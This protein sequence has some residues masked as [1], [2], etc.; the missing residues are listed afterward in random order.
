MNSLLLNHCI[1][2]AWQTQTLALPNPSVAAI[3]TNS[4]GEILGIGTHCLAGSPHAEVIALKNAYIKL[5]N[6]TSLQSIESSDEIHK[7]LIAKHKDI[8][9]QCYLFVTLEP[10]NHYGKT[11]PCAN[12]IKELDLAKIFIA[13]K[14]SSAIAQGGADILRQSNIIVE[15]A[16]SSIAKN[17]KDLLYPFEMLRD[18]NS[19]VL[20]KLATRL[21]G[22]YNANTTSGAR[23]SGAD[24]QKF[25]HNQR[26]ICNHIIISG[27]T[28]KT[29]NP[30][31]DSRFADIKYKPKSIQEDSN[32]AR[33]LPK[34]SI[35]SRSLKELPKESNLAK[36]T[37]RDIKICNDISQLDL[38]GF[39]IIE[40]GLTMLDSV[41]PFIDMLL[42]HISTSLCPNP[43]HLTH[44]VLHNFKLLKSVNFTQDLALWLK[45]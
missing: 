21:D 30:L 20:F 25:T 19:F 38:S 1:D 36:Q 8:F 18:K 41:L 12:L 37:S 34:V 5:T 29:D 27:N 44:N 35:L 31:L 43:S 11:P 39:C 7:F 32:L 2:L 24:S 26:S 17:A 22:S 14:E 23:I 28:L 6:D 40:G 9:N 33:F 45:V 42:L 3:V 16:T 10:C 15:F 4:N 13:A